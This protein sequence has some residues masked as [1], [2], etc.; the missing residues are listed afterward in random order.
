MFQIR[1]D[2][3]CLILKT[4][5]SVTY[6]RPSGP[7]LFFRISVESV[8]SVILIAPY[9]NMSAIYVSSSCAP[10]PPPTSNP[11]IYVLIVIGPR[12][13]W[14][15]TH[16]RCTVCRENHRQGNSS[17]GVQNGAWIPP[18]ELISNGGCRK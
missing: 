11:D 8:S 10:Q 3:N 4:E 9:F 18:G 2:F 13:A 14:R 1:C 15:E 16:I 5:H 12:G 6:I 7:F 17:N